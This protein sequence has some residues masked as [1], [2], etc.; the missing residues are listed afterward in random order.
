MTPP[1]V[2]KG[3]TQPR[4]AVWLAEQSSHPLAIARYGRRCDHCGANLRMG[5][6][7][8]IHPIHGQQYWSL[9]AQ[10]WRNSGRSIWNVKDPSAFVASWKETWAEPEDFDFNERISGS[11]ERRQP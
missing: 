6:P 2:V 10:A 4:E 9:G 8:R 7:V 11:D 5:Y 1:N 3:W